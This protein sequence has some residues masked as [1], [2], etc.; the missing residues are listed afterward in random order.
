M[1]GSFTSTVGRRFGL[2]SVEIIHHMG[3]PDESRHALECQYQGTAGY[4]DIDAPIHDGDTVELDDPRTG[5]KM[6]HFV[7]SVELNHSPFPSSPSFIKA[8]WGSP[9]KDPVPPVVHNTTTIT[10]TGD[11]NAVSAGVG[12][13]ALAQRISETGP[14]EFQAPSASV[15][16]I[17]KA[18]GDLS[19][20]DDERFAV[21]D[22]AAPLL[23]SLQ[24][25]VP[26]RSLIRRLLVGLKNAVVGLTHSAN[27]GANVAV[28]AFADEQVQ[29]LLHRI[30]ALT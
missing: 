14:A 23:E 29:A 2:T 11:Y 6:Q 8:N 5:G 25:E 3:A 17:L 13:I 15:A 27:A 1:A 4:F 9:P 28:A 10:V 26:D 22:S 12:A 7:P 24:A 21:L 16:H 18:L 20:G 30:Q 19:V